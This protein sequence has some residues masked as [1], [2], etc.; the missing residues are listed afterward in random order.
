MEYGEE[1]IPVFNGEL[2]VGDIDLARSII[3]SR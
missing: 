1:G 2:L 3:N